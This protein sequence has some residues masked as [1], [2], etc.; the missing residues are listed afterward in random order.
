[1]PLWKLQTVGGQQLEFL[2]PNIGRGTTIELFPGVA[3]A[4][5]AFHELIVELIRGAWLRYVR[6]YNVAALGDAADL[7]AFLFGSER[8]PLQVY[9]PVLEDLQQGACFYCGRPL[10]GSTAVDH[11]IPWSRY[12]VDLG[13][14]FVLAHSGCNGSKSDYLAAEPHLSAWLARNRQHGV[15]LSARFDHFGVVHDL[16]SSVQVARWAYTQLDST[17]G[18]VWVDHRTMAPLTPAWQTLFSTNES[19]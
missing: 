1:M 19:N 7:G 17:D 10:G 18:R 4:F 6:Q 8:A 2:Y 11:F 14:N 15:E 3:A 16:G 9:R 13:H 12:P 5:R